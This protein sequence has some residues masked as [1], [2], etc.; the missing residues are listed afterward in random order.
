MIKCLEC[1][2]VFRE[3]LIYETSY[4]S[5]YGISSDFSTSTYL[6]LELCPAC[7]SECVE[8]IKEEE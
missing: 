8:E 4:E 7:G 3:P 1:R 5:Y 2:E 6:K